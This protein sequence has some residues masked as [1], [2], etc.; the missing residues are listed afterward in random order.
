VR[1]LRGFLFVFILFGLTL[2]IGLPL[3]P[4]TLPTPV[5]IP[6]KT[7]IDGA[8]GYSEIQVSAS[9]GRLWAL[10]YAPD[11]SFNAGT[12]ARLLWKMTNGRGD[13][14]LIAVHEDGT[15]VHPVWGPVSRR[16]NTDWT[17]LFFIVLRQAKRDWKD[18]PS[19]RVYREGSD[20]KHPGQEW[21]SEFIFPKAGCWRIFVSRWLI[22]SDEAITGEIAIEVKN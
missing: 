9:S 1:I 15:Q 8:S 6:S 3:F 18:L 4:R 20:W 19:M 13:I 7:R 16:G 10:L 2:T 12:N 21:G 22:E 14:K 11:G 5:C 17:G